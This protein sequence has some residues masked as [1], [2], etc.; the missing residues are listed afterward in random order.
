MSFTEANEGKKESI[1]VDSCSFVVKQSPARRRRVSGG[2]TLI[3]LLVVIA[4]LMVLAGL[5]LAAVSRAEARGHR[6]ACVSNF[7]QFGIAHQLYVDDHTDHLLPNLDGQEIPLGKTWVEGWLGLPG[8]DCTNTLYLKRSLLGAYLSDSRVWQCPSAEPV[9]V[10][11]V[12]QD[13]VR[14]LSLNC[15]LGSPVQSPAAKTYRRMGDVTQPSPSEMVTF[16]EERESTI[17]DGAFS[18]QWDFDETKPSA[19]LLR[20]KPATRHDR[21]GNLAFADG[22][23][24]VRQW[25]DARTLSPPRDDAPM[26]GNKDIL[27]M[28]KHG[29]WREE[30]TAASPK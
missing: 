21:S 19:W 15:F 18:L 5:L 22:H 29:T 8:P 26:P 1:R 4:I 11:R 27:W 30:K 24:E 14:T 7:K 3:E 20:D 17:N 10:A 6:I 25:N 12:T 28:Q 9:T 13:R 2:F 23:V 16:L